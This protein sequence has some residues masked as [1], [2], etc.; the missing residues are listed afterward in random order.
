MQNT[1]N[2]HP[3]SNASQYIK[4]IDDIVKDLVR[5][6]PPEYFT[7]VPYSGSATSR[8]ATL[9]PLIPEN[10]SQSVIDNSTIDDGNKNGF[11]T[12]M[13]LHC[14]H[15]PDLCN[16]NMSLNIKN[17]KIIKTPADGTCL[18]HA[19]LISTSP[20]YRSLTEQDRT[21]VGRAF[22]I[23]LSKIGGIFDSDTID[24]LKQVSIDPNTPDSIYLDPF[25]LIQMGAYFNFNALIFS[26]P[27]NNASGW[28]PNIDNI[29]ITPYDYNKEAPS[30]IL[31]NNGS[32]IQ[33]ANGQYIFGSGAHYSAV[34]I[35]ENQYI[36]PANYTTDVIVNYI[37]SIN[38]SEN[39]SSSSSSSSPP[40]V[41]NQP[42]SGSPQM[43]ISTE[44]K[45]SSIPED[46]FESNG[47]LYNKKP[48]LVTVNGIEFNVYSEYKK[49][50]GK[51]R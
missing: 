20:T 19:V 23:E 41:T 25:L 32:K 12:A 40:N 1:N 22:R 50:G 30:I 15:Y 8:A 44:P 16:D 28:L 24:L 5:E 35:D 49:R 42:S 36:L 43:L 29:I 7:D 39:G 34:R 13:Q 6:F 46:A 45:S 31:Y 10:A 2:T 37:K 14:A 51:R 38:E 33:N 26:K 48:T 3:V 47:V 9:H 17:L 21:V 18:L 11:N 27:S 4:K